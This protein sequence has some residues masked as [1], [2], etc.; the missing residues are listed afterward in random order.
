MKR[1]RLVVPVWF[2][3]LH[4]LIVPPLIWGRYH[5]W[6]TIRY[7]LGRLHWWIDHPVFEA[8]RSVTH[9]LG[10][11]IDYLV[12]RKHVPLMT[13]LLSVESILFVI[14]GGLLYAFLGFILGLAIELRRRRR[15]RPGAA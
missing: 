15:P 1:P 6:S 3:S 8:V 12:L 10:W 4:T 9:R 7:D 13:A 11:L 2:V 5:L 14:L